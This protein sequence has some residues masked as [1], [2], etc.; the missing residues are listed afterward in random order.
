MH[1]TTDK[2][3]FKK[4][5]GDLLASYSILYAISL[6]V[7]LALYTLSGDQIWLI[8]FVG[9]FLEWVLLPTL[10]LFPL[11][12]WR[13][14][15]LASVL[16]GINATAFLVLFGGQFI[17]NMGIAVAMADSG[18]TTLTVMTYNTNS[19]S[20]RLDD[21]LY[22]LREADADV[23]GL[24]ELGNSSATAIQNELLDVYPYQI[25]Y[26]YG[27]Q[28][29]GVLSHY[30]IVSHEYVEGETAFPYLVATLDVD[31]HL[32]TVISAHPPSPMRSLTRGVYY[33]RGVEDVQSIA[34]RAGN[35]NPTL[36]LGD[37]NAT[38]HSEEYALLE[39]AELVDSFQKA[40][41]GFGNT[42]PAG[43]GR[44][45][46]GVPMVRI[47]YIWH[48]GDFRTTDVWVGADGGS[49]HLPVYAELVW[50]YS[51]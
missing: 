4:L 1:K 21:L 10:I 3:T 16:V 49:D 50:Q 36:L 7:L 39:D 23:V 42:F 34:D 41:W 2:L 25:L 15:W 12:L 51:T 9:N 17:P 27:T 5:F 24:Q 26:G 8:G 28:G 19:E 48:T 46:P 43:P 32:L 38:P 18:H 6:I 30:P 20:V 45:M 29:V 13:R 40:G 22:T 31:G 47:D 11:M 37:L 35:G 44:L 33:S 14:R